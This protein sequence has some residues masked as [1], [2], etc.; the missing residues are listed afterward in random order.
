MST[1]RARCPEALCLALLANATMVSSDGAAMLV[2]V[3][4]PVDP[5]T[6]AGMRWLRK[7]RATLIEINQAAA[8]AAAAAAAAATVAAAVASEAAAAAGAAAAAVAVGVGAD[9]VDVH[10]EWG[11]DG[12]RANGDVDGPP[13]DG[14]TVE[15]VLSGG[16][17]MIVVDVVQAVYAA[18][19]TMVIAISAA[20]YLVLALF[21]RSLVLPLRALASMVGRCRLT[22]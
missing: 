22:L 15:W 9:D 5:L 18:F 21:F 7:T 3:T 8:D 1:C 20:I 11:V 12:A 2:A 17:D 16:T 10:V 14:M 19:P 4:P 13:D 6:A